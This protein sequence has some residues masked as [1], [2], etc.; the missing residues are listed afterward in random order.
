M[1]LVGPT[2]SG[3][4]TLVML[5]PRLYDVTARRRAGGRRRRA[6]RRPRL[7]APRGCGGFRRCLPLLRQPARQ[8]RLRPPGGRRRRGLAAADACRP[9]GADRR[10]ARGARHA[11]GRARPHPERRPAPAGGHRARAAGRAA[12]PDPRRCHLERGCHHREPHQVRALAE[13]MEGRTTFIIAHRLSTIALADE[14]VVL[15][16]GR[17]AARGPHAEL[18]ERSELYREIAE[19]GLPDQVFLTR[20]DPER[21]VAGLEWREAEKATPP[22]A[23]AAALPRPRGAHAGRPDGGHR[24]RT[25]AALPGRQGD[26]RRHQRRRHGRA[27]DHPGSVRRRRGGQLGGRRTPRPSSSAG[28]ASARCRTCASSSSPTSSGSRSAS[29]RATRPAC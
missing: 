12:H 22:A 29:T 21:E 7:P 25:G 6:R 17:V 19:K 10:S 9:R 4:T 28:S 20:D 23:P 14:V 27:H 15:E 3:K 18:L 1:A 16:D 8:H 24:R 26:R 11:R 5:I 13:V 2:G